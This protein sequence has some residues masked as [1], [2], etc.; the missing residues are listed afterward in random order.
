MSDGFQSFKPQ[1]LTPGIPKEQVLELPAV[2]ELL[3]RLVEEERER[4]FEAGKS[5]GYEQGLAE[6]KKQGFE[7]GLKE[8]E[9][10]QAAFAEAADKCIASL[11]R[12]ERPD[13]E[14]FIEQSRQVLVSALQGIVD[15]HSRY[16][17]VFATSVIAELDKISSSSLAVAMQVSKSIPDRIFE[18]L[19]KHA[20][21]IERVDI[22]E[23]LR[24]IVNEDR[25]VFD[26]SEVVEKVLEK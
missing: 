1:V 2:R 8:F 4:G 20:A 22:P 13:V 5:E 21:S 12:V 9:A 3:R 16:G 23:P 18:V 19:S 24:V 7:L 6:G 11:S 14:L 26:V 10:K 15:D 17:D 25:F